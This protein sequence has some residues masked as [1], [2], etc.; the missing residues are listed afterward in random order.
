MQE[1]VLFTFHD[2]LINA[3]HLENKLF[4]YLIFFRSFLGE[5]YEEKIM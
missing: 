5:C 4:D 2:W 3:K 1:F